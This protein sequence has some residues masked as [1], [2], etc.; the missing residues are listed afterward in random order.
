MAIKQMRGESSVA[1]SLPADIETTELTLNS[2]G[3]KLGFPCELLEA[4]LGER[5]QQASSSVTAPVV[6]SLQDDLRLLMSQL[7]QHGADSQQ[8][9]K[10]GT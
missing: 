8:I 7:R 5:K 2:E 4:S 3:Q 6:P 9:T 10:P 1:R